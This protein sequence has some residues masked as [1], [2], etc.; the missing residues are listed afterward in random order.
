VVVVLDADHRQVLA[1]GIVGMAVVTCRQW[2]VGGIEIFEPDALSAQVAAM[3]WT[4]LRGARQ[5]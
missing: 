1:Y 5:V 3:A 2:I 4:G